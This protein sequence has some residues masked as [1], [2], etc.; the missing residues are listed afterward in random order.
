MMRVLSTTVVA[1]IVLVGAQNAGAE[2]GTRFLSP[3]RHIFASDMPMVV[4]VDYEAQSGVEAN[5]DPLKRDSSILLVEAA[6]QTWEDIACTN[7]DF[8][9][10]TYSNYDSSFTNDGTSI[11][12]FNDPQGDLGTGTLAAAVT[13]FSGTTESVN[14]VNWSQITNFDIVFNDGIPFTT[15]T[16]IANP[17][18]S[19]LYDMQAVALHEIGHG[20]G[21]GHPCGIDE[22]CPDADKQSSIMYPT[23]GPC[24][25]KRTPQAYDL[26]T[27]SIA[28]GLGSV[29]SFTGDTPQG[30]TPL[31]V[32]FSPLTIASASIVST[33]WNFG[34][35]ITSTD[36]NPS[37]TY[38]SE[39]RYTVT[40]SI[41]A[42]SPSCGGNFT[43]NVRKVDYVVACDAL[44]PKFEY[45][46]SGK[47]VQFRSLTEG[48]AAGCLQVLEWDFGDGSPI[49]YVKNPIHTY[50]DGGEYTVTLTAKG[51]GSPTGA[52]QTAAVK[53]GGGGKGCSVDMQSRPN[54]A[55][56]VGA[57]MAAVLLALGATRRR[58][59]A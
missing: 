42:N 41:T 31:T 26:E 32:T 12:T 20:I 55:A 43:Q 17:A 19:G 33:T 52:A 38:V 47:K 40:A 57:L 1:G 39:G 15:P 6:L 54:Q 18:C 48:S 3:E 4:N 22:S 27:H 25:D 46:V 34:D 37:H 58:T 10:G 36:T 2:V 45:D 30:P 53:T 35:G 49:Q 14:G 44:E 11:V 5:G 50:A 23:I 21:Y 16:A 9:Q 51:P 56:A 29:S 28:Y 59:R 7:I 13:W 8:G 24:T